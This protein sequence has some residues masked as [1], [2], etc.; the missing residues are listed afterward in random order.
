MKMYLFFLFILNANKIMLSYFKLEQN[1]LI[2]EDENIFH[3][4][5][6]MKLWEI[7]KSSKKEYAYSLLKYLF[8][9][10]SFRSP[11]FFYEESDKKMMCLEQCDLKEKDIPECMND[12]MRVYKEIEESN[13]V[14]RLF[15]AYYMG[16]DKLIA[17]INQ[18]NFS[19]KIESGARKGDLLHNVK[20]LLAV[21][22]DANKT[23]EGIK[24]MEEAYRKEMA[25]NTK[26]RGKVTIG[27]LH[28]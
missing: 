22:K 6:I 7:D 20:D 9:M 8:L 5:E 15:K 16:H 25:E 12:A 24:I 10:C 18:V 14:L 3:L 23:I 4:K 28:S 13:P 21:L 11:Y 26:T 1:R 2:I 17:Y 19:E 27:K